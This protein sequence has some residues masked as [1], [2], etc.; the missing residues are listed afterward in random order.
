VPAGTTGSTATTPATQPVAL[1]KVFKQ[2]GK[3]YAQLTINGAVYAPAVGQT[4]AQT[5][6]L[7]SVSGH[8]ATLVQGDEQFSLNVGQVVVR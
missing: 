5:F 4:F 3:T 1:Q 7:L 8:T 6:Q 2:N